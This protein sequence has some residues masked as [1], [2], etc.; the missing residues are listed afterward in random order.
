[1]INLCVPFSDATDLSRKFK[2]HGRKGAVAVPYDYATSCTVRRNSAFTDYIRRHHYSWYK[3]ATSDGRIIQP[4]DLVLVSG[5]VKTSSWSLATWVTERK[6]EAFSL[7]ADHGSSV[8]AHVDVERT[9]EYEVPPNPR[10]KLPQ[11]GQPH[12]QCLFVRYYKAK[13]R[14]GPL[15]LLGMKTVVPVRPIAVDTYVDADGSGM[16]QLEASWS[17]RLT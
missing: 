6:A 10:Y 9:V 1:M 2:T 8:H 15:K 3:Y 17:A 16:V 7:S 13:Y 5:W 4:E 14:P 12:N 11:P